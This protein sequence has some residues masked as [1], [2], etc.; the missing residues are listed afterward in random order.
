MTRSDVEAPAGPRSDAEN[1]RFRIGLA[2]VVAV[3]LAIRLAYVL[4]VKGDQAPRGDAI[5]YFLQGRQV[6]DGHGFVNAGLLAFRGI[7]LP[8]ADHPPLFTFFLALLDLLGIRTFLGARLG[9]AIVSVVTLVLVGLVGR[10]IAGP[11]AG[12]LAA[13]VAAVS[14]LI[15][16]NDGQIL[17]ESMMMLAVAGTVLL[18]YRFWALPDWRTAALFGAACGV[19]ALVR[20]EAL[21][22]APAIAIPLVVGMRQLPGRRRIELLVVAGIAGAVVFA[23]WAIRNSLA[24]EHPVPFGTDADITLENTNCQSTYYG[25]LLGWWDQACATTPS[26][27]LDQ[28]QTA[29]KQRRRALDFIDDHLSRVPVVAL[30]RAGRLWGVFRPIQT[31]DLMRDEGR[32]RAV[33]IA[34]L[35]ALY[36]TLPTAF[37]GAV[38]LRRRRIPI[39]PLVAP[40]FVS[41]LSAMVAFGNPRYRSSAD[42]VLVVLV[43]VALDALCERRGWGTR[44]RGAA[45][46]G[47]ASEAPTQHTE[48]ADE[49]DPVTASPSD[50]PS[51]VEGLH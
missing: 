28:S 25:P 44:L 21:L 3:G 37:V 7:S 13:A 15:W 40:V 51:V 49:R 38:L 10:R 31:V 18:A 23:P 42:I 32:E 33:G 47:Q 50:D 24:L 29:P 14:P 30:A 20:G 12:L 19:T 27:T 34:G 43:A 48:P 39:S 22:L 17:S 35:L 9:V 16:V 1:R 26:L 4:I 11:R 2:I 45:H 8:V 6:A 36:L 41:T 46:P 5:T